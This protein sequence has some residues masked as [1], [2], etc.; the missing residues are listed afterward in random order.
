M[1]IDAAT[2]TQQHAS[3]EA[4]ATEISSDHNEPS[5][6]VTHHLH[7]RQ[8]RQRVIDHD[9]DFRLRI[10]SSLDGA[11]V[12]LEFTPTHRVLT[13]CNFVNHHFEDIQM[14]VREYTPHNAKIQL[15]VRASYHQTQDHSE[16][17]TLH[18]STVSKSVTETNQSF[19]E[20]INERG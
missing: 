3:E 9:G 19:K 2:S 12:S 4:V 1:Q 14:Y 7:H 18:H 17:S 11:C 8:R 20:F 6:V 16:T 10:L 15:Y 5:D 13:V